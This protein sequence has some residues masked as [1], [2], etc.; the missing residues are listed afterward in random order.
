MLSEQ[1]D[2][3]P[4]AHTGPTERVIGYLRGAIERGELKAGDQLPPERELAQRFSVSRPTVRSVLRTLAAMGVVQIRQGAGTFMTTGPPTLDSGPLAYLAALHGITRRQMFEARMS[5]EVAVSSLAAERANAESL[6]PVSEATT[7]MFASLDRPNAFLDHDIQ[8]HR[9]VAAAA[10]NPV[11]AAMVDMVSAMFLRIR[12]RSIGHATDLRIAAEE[13][14]AIYL[15]IRA[16][17][18]ARARKAMADH[19]QRAEKAQVAEDEVPEPPTG[20]VPALVGATPGPGE[21]EPQA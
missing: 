8:F 14:R 12:R 13:H 10:G 20:V 7:A 2:P 15:A 19:L 6:I 11:L 5:L 3:A 4:A 16:G 9:A 21:P 1:V 18:P 17:D